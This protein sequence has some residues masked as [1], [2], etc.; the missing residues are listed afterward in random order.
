MNYR[1]QV[2]DDHKQT[3]IKRHKNRS[4]GRIF[5]Q[6]AIHTFLPSVI[7]IGEADAP[8]VSSVKNLGVTLDSNLCMSQDI[9]NTCKTAYIQLRHI[10]SISHLLTTHATQT[11]VGSLVLSRLDHCNSLL[12]GCPQY[13]LNK[14]QKVQNATAR[15]VC[16]VNKS[17]H[18][19]PIL[20]SL[21]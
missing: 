9:N 11:L 2:L 8:F 3:S 6:N 13:L 20:Q 18:I 14:L 15:L 12:S 21:H 16:K 5:T 1:S 4:H 7:N 17:D 19:K 10:S